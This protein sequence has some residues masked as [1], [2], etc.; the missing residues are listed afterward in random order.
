[1][2]MASVHLPA[3]ADNPGAYAFIGIEIDR[4]YFNLAAVRISQKHH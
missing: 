3:S 4:V 1:M 2:T